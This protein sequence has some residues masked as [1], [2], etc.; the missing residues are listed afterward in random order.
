MLVAGLAPT[1]EGHAL[2]LTDEA[3]R[4]I[5][6]IFIG[7]SEALAI[8]LRIERRVAPR[9]LTHDLLD[10]L[11][12]RLGGRLVLVRIDDLRNDVFHA[13]VVVTRGGEVIEVDSRA[14]DAV[15]LAVGHGMAV[16]VAPGVIREAGV[17]AP[18][19]A[20]PGHTPAKPLLPTETIDL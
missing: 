7:E 6:P 12:S 3:H 14:S 15:V 13:A 9:P 5:V 4:I 11:V 2:V 19:R 8:A 10:T 20:A 16:Y 1:P 18:R 17:N